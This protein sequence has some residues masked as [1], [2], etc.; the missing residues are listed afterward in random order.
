MP[1]PE[2]TTPSSWS[3][4]SATPDD[5][6]WIVE[7]N[8]RLAWESES[9]VLERNILTRG[10]SKALADSSRL[11]YWVAEDGNRPI[12][13]AAV[14]HEWSDWRDGWIWWFQSVYVIREYRQKGV[15]RALYQHIHSLARAEPDVIGF[16]LY[17][18][19]ENQSAHAAYHSL[20]LK[21][22]GYHVFEELWP[23]RLKPAHR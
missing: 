3:I 6:S 5:L 20:G 23:D 7:F 11:R 9:K 18:E 16:R 14:T 1:S 22:G 12:G 13:Q 19:A 10:V 17:V 2:L 21:P 4:R 15:F 8:Y